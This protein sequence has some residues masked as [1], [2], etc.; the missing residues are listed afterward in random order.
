MI[1]C[2]SNFQRSKAFPAHVLPVQ[3][4]DAQDDILEFLDRLERTIKSVERGSLSISLNKKMFHVNPVDSWRILSNVNASNRTSLCVRNIILDGTKKIEDISGF[5]GWISLLVCV[6]GMRRNLRHK[7][8][9]HYSRSLATHDVNKILHQLSI[10][11]QSTNFK[12]LNKV[13]KKGLRDDFC[14]HLVL[15][16]YEIVG[17]D[18][19]IFIHKDP[20]PDTVVELINGHK[21]SCDIDPRFIA[22]TK[23]K[24]WDRTFPKIFIIDGMIE[25]VSEINRVLEDAATK[26][27]S[28]V[29]LCLGYSE[30]VIATLSVNYMR[31][32]LDILPIAPRLGIENI[33]LTTDVAVVVGS[34]VISSH[35]GELVS[36]LDPDEINIVDRV[37]VDRQGM[38]IQNGRSKNCAAAHVKQLLEKR[39][40]ESMDDKVNLIN[41]RLASLTS[42]YCHV[43]LGSCLKE[44][45]SLI[46]GRIEAGI[47][48]GREVSRFGIINI[49]RAISCLDNEKPSEIKDIIRNVL[50]RL[51]DSGHQETSSPSLILGIQ[52]GLSCLESVSSTGYFLISD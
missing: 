25:R 4:D 51:L 40:E 26:K 23:I 44:E 37:T 42:R 45:L 5:A 35:K 14:S 3:W 33:N 31:G 43:K 30:E 48:L 20:A 24:K 49:P 1:K 52:G 29:L 28:G 17:A 10:L 41:L 47:K 9:D 32:S 34:D 39:D 16:A 6:E 38:L 27:Y 18:G 13:V 50:Q 2:P 12:T 11:S 36:S 15:D 22:S 8:N 21:F 19:Q 7:S 46:M